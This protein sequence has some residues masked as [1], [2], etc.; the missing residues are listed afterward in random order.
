LTTKFVLLPPIILNLLAYK[1]FKDNCGIQGASI[2]E[3]YLLSSPVVNSPYLYNHRKNEAM[4]KVVKP[5]ELPIRTLHDFLLE[6]N[7]EWNRFRTGSLLNIV[8]TIILF[9]IFI[10]TSFIISLRRAGPFDTLLLLG[11]MAALIYNTYLAYRQYKFYQKWERRLGLLLH[12]EE[13]ILNEM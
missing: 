3:V 5:E 9:A 2:I 7:N 12:L 6:I 11:I 1:N 4:N 10:P 8:T 13:Q